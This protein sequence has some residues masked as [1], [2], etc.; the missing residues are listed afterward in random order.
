LLKDLASG[1]FA[2]VA[3]FFVLSGFILSYAHAGPS[4]HDGCDVKASVFWRLRFGRIAPAY[5]LG[6]LLSIP[7]VAYHL[8]VLAVTGWSRFVGPV[9]VILFLQAW[10]PRFALL[11]NFPAWSLSVECLFYAVFPSLARALARVPR[12]TLFAITYALSGVFPT[13]AFALVHIRNGLGAPFP[14]WSDDFNK[15]AR[16][17]AMGRHLSLAAALRRH[18]PISVVD[19]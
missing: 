6:L 14:F 8:D 11:W 17:H 9:L 2:A 13:L 7:F 1:G 3:F 10:W 4:E 16:G 5:Y 18:A 12:T 15:D 19:A